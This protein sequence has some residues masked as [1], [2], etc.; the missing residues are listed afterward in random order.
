M[1]GR[2]SVRKPSLSVDKQPVQ[3]RL[4]VGPVD[5][6]LEK[7][8]D[9]VADRVL[10]LPEPIG[11]SRASGKDSPPV[12][13]AAPLGSAGRALDES[14]R[15]YFE[16]RFGFDFSKVRIH[17]DDE[18]AAS[19]RSLGALAYTAG[20]EIAFDRA[21]YQP[22]SAEGRRLLAHE[23]THVVQQGQATA[24][25]GRE[26]TRPAPGRAGL[27]I[28]RD[29]PEGQQNPQQIGPLAIHASADM[30]SR[31]EVTQALTDYLYKVQKEQG[32]QTLHVDEA[33]RGA[34]LRLFQGD[35][36]G[37]I[38]AE[39]LLKGVTPSDPPAFAA[40]VTKFLPDFV[41]RTRAAFLGTL[42]A[43]VAA[44]TAPKSMGE[45]AGKVVVDSTVAPIVKKLPIPKD[46]QDK[47]IDA[48]KDGVTAGLVAIVDQAMSDSPLDDKAKGAIH[49]AVEA[50]IKQ[51][52]GTPMD[53]QQE[54][55]GSP[56][57]QVQP[58]GVTPGFP[59]AP[60][61]HI[62]NLPSIKWDIPTKPLP[63]PNLPEPP[64]AS[65][66]KGVDSIIQ[67]L[68][69]QSLI[70]A[71]AKGKPEAGEFAGAK[72]L[73]RSIANMLQAANAKKRYT[74]DLDLPMGYRHQPDLM[75]IFDKVEAIVKQV[76]A[77]I[78][79]GIPNVGEVIISPAK[80]PDDKTFPARRIVRLRG[81][82]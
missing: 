21:Q 41:P 42:P 22:G 49:S 68:D 9:H 45:A 43:K 1:F 34:V 53:R 56:Y 23:L 69:D 59:T 29:V 39:G 50:A 16:P 31:Q 40:A 55:A 73:A 24:L 58:P 3:T 37:S 12:L 81:G 52:A 20:S 67:G 47:I 63:K 79:G 26:G 8:A 35:V 27:R 19:A 28:Q 77:A 32:G 65:E 82:D 76:A 2:L 18:A 17:A 60:G 11:A 44:D 25:P 30:V 14:S 70:P 62:F 80:A 75:D 13:S 4:A 46:W 66:A 54:G 64:T 72:E 5:D 71:A 78:P 48:A 51:K 61:E 38:S 57:A 15:A 7:E 36:S 33:V 10:R 6:P 74:V